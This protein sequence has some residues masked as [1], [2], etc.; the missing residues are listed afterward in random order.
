MT[1]RPVI[2]TLLLAL[3]ACGSESPTAPSSPSATSSSAV[4]LTAANF[5]PLVIGSAKGSMVDFYLPT[6]SHCQAM[7]PIVSSI[8]DEFV[9]QA[10]VGQVD[11]SIETGLSSSYQIQYVPT[12]I[13]FKNGREVERIVGETTRDRLVDALRAAMNAS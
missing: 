7:A 12:F 3:A 10:V 13:F 9:G 2:L 1:P 4:V 11:V 6:C 8:A 5:T